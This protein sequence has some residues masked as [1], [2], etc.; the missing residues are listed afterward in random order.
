MAL[1]NARQTGGATLG[2]GQLENL[3]LLGL[4]IVARAADPTAPGVAAKDL[5]PSPPH[6]PWET[7]SPPAPRP[8]PGSKMHHPAAFPTASPPRT[9]AG[10]RRGLRSNSAELGTAMGRGA[11]PRLAEHPHPLQGPCSMEGDTNEESRLLSPPRALTMAMKRPMKRKYVRWS[12]L[13]EE[14]GL[15]C[16]Q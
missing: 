6:S 8:S 1:G 15:I 13:M 5:E 3:T 10:A 16:R 11:A 2:L 12:G 7:R 9:H 14:A 4:K